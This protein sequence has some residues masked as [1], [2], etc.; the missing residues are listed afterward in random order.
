MRWRTWLSLAGT[1]VLMVPLAVMWSSSLL[2]NPLSV[3]D[4]GGPDYGSGPAGD[5]HG[6]HGSDGAG[7]SLTTLVADPDRPADVRVE[8]R[9]ETATLVEG[10]RDVP[11]YTVNGTSPGPEIRARVGQLVEVHLVNVSVAAGVTLHW[12]G[13]E[14]PNAMDGVAGVTQDSVPPGGEFTYRFIPARAGTFWYHS[15]QTSHEQVVGGLFGVVVIEPARATAGA[16]DPVD[17]VAVAHT[18]AGV[19]TING[20]AE[21]LMIP[22]EPGASVRLRV[23]NTDNGTLTV[24]SG[25]PVTV[26]AVDG[27]E[28]RSPA[29]V[30]DEQVAVAAGGRIDLVVAVPATG[31]VRVQ[32]S[33]ATAVV[34]GPTGSEPPVPAQPERWLDLLGYGSPGDVG[35]DPARVDRHFDYV[36]TQRPG[37][38]KGRPGIWW[39]INGLLYPNVPMFVVTEGELV[40]MHIENH[41]NEVHPM[42]LHGHRVLVVA[43]DGVAASGSPWWTDSFDVKPG[44]TFDIVFRADNPGIWMDHCHN[45][46]HARDGM[47][48]HLAYA[49]I[50][51]PFRLGGDAG[52]EPE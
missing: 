26:A 40:G 36:V 7:T 24:W 49:G 33:K 44:E 3:M 14:V 18:Y 22:A 29:P 34:I 30:R 12:H 20:R 23:V 19:R 11:G 50:S 47:V 46:E 16:G 38:V 35:F 28:V 45:L 10:G 15:H 39:A 31:A 13:M 1:A 2:R 8:L 6:H 37:F 17:A 42:H 43:R 27:N 51:T 9:T 5:G 21:D 32:L 4:M 48:A 52:N 41:T 25:E